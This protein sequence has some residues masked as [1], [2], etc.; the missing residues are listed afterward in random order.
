MANFSG[1]KK[2]RVFFFFGRLLLTI[3]SPFRASLS[4]Y[5]LV[6]ASEVFAAIGQLELFYDQAPDSMRSCCSALALLSTA[7]GGYIAG[8]LIPLI[9]AIT[10]RTGGGEWIPSNLND[11]RLDLFFYTIAGLNTLNFGEL[12]EIHRFPIQ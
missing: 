3:P 2:K 1:A 4:Q 10:S 9:N 8:G 12:L 5:L 6:G 11:G 7:M